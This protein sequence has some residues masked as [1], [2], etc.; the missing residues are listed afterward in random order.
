MVT[1]HYLDHASTSPARPEV[2][3]AVMA[4]LAASG[5]DPGRIHAEG[6]E[7]RVG[8]GGRPGAGGGAA[9]G[10]AAVGRLHERSHRGD[11]GRL[12]GCCGAGRP[13]GARGGRALRRPQG[14]RGHTAR[15][16]S[17][18]STGIGRVDPDALLA[19]V[20][21][22][23]RAR[24]RPVG[25]PRG[26]HH[27]SPSRRSSRRAASGVSS[28]TSTPRRPTATCPSGST[29]SAPTS[30]RCRPTSSAAL[31]GVGALLVRRG[32]RVRPLLTGGDQE[33]ARR[34]GLEPVALHRWASAPPRPPCR[35]ALDR[36]A[37]TQRALTDRVLAAVPSLEGRARLRR[38]RRPPPPP[39]VPRHRRRRAAGR[40][41]RPRP[42]R[43][44]RPLG[45]SV[46]V[47][48]A[49][50][51]TRARGDGRRRPPQPAPERRLEHH[52]RRRR[53]G[54]QRP[55]RHPPRP[56]RPGPADLP[57]PD[58]R[59][60]WIIGPWQ[61]RRCDGCSWR[62]SDGTGGSCA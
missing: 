46:L 28:S 44:R 15:S 11:R 2:V 36:E 57:L 25:Q 17:S 9:R 26:G 56:P 3:A 48:G 10:P 13:P 24:A 1:R 23:H 29:S 33:R 19:A 40:A 5:G 7:A 32:L 54:P 31:P 61:R 43:R 51:V 58:P 22:R 49:R 41:A 18:A 55:P 4:R 12:L 34:A 6:L 8:G 42:G 60:G 39:R 35:P 45:V 53:C 38:S 20:R 47:R 21:G 30:C 27:A 59:G 14:S 37:A 50:T 62:M 16:P 52:R